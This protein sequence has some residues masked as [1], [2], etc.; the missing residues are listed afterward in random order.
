VKSS[1]WI[2]PSSA[3]AKWC[4]AGED[5]F[6]TVPGKSSCYKR[7]MSLV[8]ISF[9]VAGAVIGFGLWFTSCCEVSRGVLLFNVQN[10]VCSLE[11]R[12]CIYVKYRMREKRSF[13]DVCR[14]SVKCSQTSCFRCF[15]KI[16]FNDRKICFALRN[17]CSILATES[18]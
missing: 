10:G 4:G 7:A 5:R 16:A 18:N 9:G 1:V 14:S 3:L 15:W 13:Q 17:S 6:F 11:V 12:L 2:L 8:Y